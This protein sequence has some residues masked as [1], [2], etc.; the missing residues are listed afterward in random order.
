MEEEGEDAAEEGEKVSRQGP[1]E[2]KPDSKSW[3]RFGV[4][5][6]HSRK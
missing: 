4:F 3:S 1:E 5:L 2:N 6:L